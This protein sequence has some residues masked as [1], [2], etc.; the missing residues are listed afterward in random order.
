MNSI[1]IKKVR[2]AASYSSFA[3]GML[4]KKHFEAGKVLCPESQLIK[5]TPIFEYV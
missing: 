5:E 1:T 2:Y 4:M 3:I